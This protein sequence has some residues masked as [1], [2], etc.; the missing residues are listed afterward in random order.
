M[1][2]PSSPH[3]ADAHQR[4]HKQDHVLR[5]GRELRRRD[6]VRQEARGGHHDLGERQQVR[7]TYEGEWE[8]GEEREGTMT[9]VDGTVQKGRF[10]NR[11]FVGP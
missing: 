10:A 9:L 1:S 11:K 5:E 8:N 6:V 7:K 2:P 3:R 4:A